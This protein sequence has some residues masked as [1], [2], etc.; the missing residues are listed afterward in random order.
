MNCNIGVGVVQSC[1][2]KGRH[3]KLAYEI[4]RKDRSLQRWGMFTFWESIML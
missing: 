3:I 2:L 1:E 4:D